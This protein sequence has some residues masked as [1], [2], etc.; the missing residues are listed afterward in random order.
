MRRI[1]VVSNSSW[2]IVNFRLNLMNSL[3][4]NGYSIVAI[5]PYDEYTDRIPFEYHSIKVNN[6]GT[7]PIEDFILIY[8]MF[9]LYRRLKPDLVLHFTVKP[10]IY[11]AI[12]ARLCRI[13]CINN[14]TGLGTL[15]VKRNLLT[16]IA[17]M[18]Y[19]VSQS[20]ASKIFFQNSDDM[21]Q[22]K[23]LNIVSNPQIEL[24]PGSGVDIERFK[25]RKKKTTKKFNFLFFG[26]VLWGKGAGEYVDAADIIHEKY[27]NVEFQ[28]LGFIEGNNPDSVPPSKMQEWVDRGAI[29]YLG[30][31]DDVRKYI[32]GADCVVLPSYY[33]EGVPRTL[34]EAASMARPI[35]TTKNIGCREVVDEGING[36]FC[37]VKDSRDLA[38]KMETMVLSSKN[39]CETMG[40]NGRKKIIEQFN[41]RII[42]NKYIRSIEEVLSS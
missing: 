29:V 32:A 35:I 36:L 16:R 31:T 13:P 38:A 19:R 11:G 23:K 2:S 8:R 22:L 7:N 40:R 17:V 15:F 28:M 18:L 25:P 6:R 33:R 20:R 27:E 5:A 26:R 12:A 39:K 37:K 24:L 42:I 4:S 34:L 3:S 41:E 1:A 9:R 10:N 14:I 30:A 21:E